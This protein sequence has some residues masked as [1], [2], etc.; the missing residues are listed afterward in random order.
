L[1][2]KASN[3]ALSEY[4]GICCAHLALRGRLKHAEEGDSCQ[5]KDKGKN[6]G[7]KTRCCSH[8][9]RRDSPCKNSI[10]GWHYQFCHQLFT[11]SCSL[12]NISCW[13]GIADLAGTRALTHTNARM[14]AAVSCSISHT[15]SDP[16]CLPGWQVAESC[17]N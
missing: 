9:S 4:S 14:A 11:P 6:T 16:E 8:L 10:H 12:E 3:M 15:P 1:T 17:R 7:R 13:P 5:N 2:G